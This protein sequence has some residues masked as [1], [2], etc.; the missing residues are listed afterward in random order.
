MKQRIT[1]VISLIALTMVIALS[2]CKKKSVED[3]EP[4]YDGK[5]DST[6]VQGQEKLDISRAKQ[7]AGSEKWNPL[8]NVSTEM[9]EEGSSSDSDVAPLTGDSSTGDPNDIDAPND[10]VDPNEVSEDFF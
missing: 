5:I 8:A 1:V 3:I 7:I 4:L 2:S 10:V 6:S 9:V